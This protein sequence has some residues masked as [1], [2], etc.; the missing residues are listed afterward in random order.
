MTDAAVLGVIERLDTPATCEKP[1]CE[2]QTPYALAI[3]LGPGIGAVMIE[4][5]RFALCPDH[6][7]AFLRE[8]ESWAQVQVK[9]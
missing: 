4:I 6:V 8:S 7:A 2:E 9:L 3:A 5:V 1:E